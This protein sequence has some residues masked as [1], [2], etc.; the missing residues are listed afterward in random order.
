MAGE[1]EAAFTK[2]DSGNLPRVTA[3]M[4]TNYFIEIKQFVSAESRGQKHIRSS[5]QSYGDSAIGAGKYCSE[6]ILKRV[7][8]EN[9]CWPRTS[10]RY[11]VTRESSLE[12]VAICDHFLPAAVML[13]NK[14][15]CILRLACHVWAI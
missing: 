13:N 9:D 7:S 6:K 14:L 12:A 8:A 15:L 2:A 5:R 10:K 11:L 3:E 1:V 4:I